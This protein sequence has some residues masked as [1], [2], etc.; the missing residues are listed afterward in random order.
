MKTFEEYNKEIKERI[1]DQWIKE[2]QHVKNM[3]NDPV[4][5]LLLSALSYQAYHI[6]KNCHQSEEKILRELRDRIL[7]FHLIKPI[8]AFSVVETKLKQ[9]NDEKTMDETC[10]FEFA[11]NKKQKFNFAPLLNTKIINAELEMIDQVDEKVWKFKLQSAKPLTNLSGLSFYMGTHEKIEIERIKY[12]DEELPLI[13]P[14]QYDQLPFTK[15]FTNAHLFLN[16]NYYLFGTYDYWQEIFLINNVRLFYIGQ[17][18]KRIA[19]NKE[20]GMELEITFNSPT[21]YANNRL[22]INCFPVVNVEKKEA[23]LDG[24]NPMKDLTSDTGQFLNLLADKENEKDMDAV[25]IRQHGVERYNSD[26]LFEQMQEMLYRY[27][28]DYYAFQSIRELNTT[29]KLENLQNVMDEIRS[30]VNKSAEKKI[31]DHYYAVLK[32]NHNETKRVRLNYLTTAGASANGIKKEEKATK[33]PISLDN[34][35]TILLIETKGGKNA[36]HD[37]SQKEDIAN[38]Y[39][40]TQDRLITPADIGIFIKTFYYDDGKL[41]DEIENISITRENEYMRIMINLKQ[42]SL[43]KNSDSLESLAEVM[44]NK[45]MLRSSGI[46]PF[47]VT[48]K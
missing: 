9:G 7:P 17:Y 44:Q 11:N 14:S 30:I 31:K 25:F 37:E 18:D 42:D 47:N 39:F 24:K 19:L 45:I 20:S 35:K 36:I 27:N 8:P 29:D 43:L 1:I 5:N 33:T 15:W 26:Q 41:D 38:Y 13:K 16:Q 32:N 48:I 46:L 34:N 22:K 2:G 21:L 12:C 28:A 3:E 40:Q 23:D 6:H 4:I 10:V